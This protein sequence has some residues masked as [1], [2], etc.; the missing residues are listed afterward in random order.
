MSNFSIGDSVI[1][2]IDDTNKVLWSGQFSSCRPIIKSIIIGQRLADG[3]K[4]AVILIPK[5]IS[6]NGWEIT[7]KN[8]KIYQ[9]EINLKY[10]NSENLVLYFYSS[11][12]Q[13]YR[14]KQC[15]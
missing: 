9:C 5:D 15:R 11:A 12:F 2:N 8:L 6:T 1:F 14:C 3:D 13:I 10:V 7:E 4:K